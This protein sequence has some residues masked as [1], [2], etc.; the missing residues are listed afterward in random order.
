MSEASIIDE[1][2]VGLTVTSK[3]AHLKMPEGWLVDHDNLV[4][5]DQYAGWSCACVTFENLGLCSHAVAVAVSE[6]PQLR[7]IGEEFL[8]CWM[9]LG[10]AAARMKAALVS[11]STNEGIAATADQ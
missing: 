2:Q 10:I 1:I 9:A 4:R 3:I 7:L 5:K 8:R 11:A 6:D